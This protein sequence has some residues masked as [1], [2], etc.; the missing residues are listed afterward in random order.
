MHPDDF[1]ERYRAQTEG[2][3]IPQIVFH[4]EGSLAISS[5]DLM[6]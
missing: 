3:I 5:M 6:P 2:I 1:L 4:G